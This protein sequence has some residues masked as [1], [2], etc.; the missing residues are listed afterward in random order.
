MLKLL[1]TDQPEELGTD[2]TVF[3]TLKGSKGT[4]PERKLQGNFFA[5]GPWPGT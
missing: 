2:S 1:H 3:I 5:K 4:S